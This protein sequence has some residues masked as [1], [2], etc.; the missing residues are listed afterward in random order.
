MIMQQ[1]GKVQVQVFETR[2]AMGESA[3]HQAA[4]ALRQA[5]AQQEKISCIF[6]AAPSQNEFLEALIAEPGIDWK[7]V[8]ACH[9]DEYVGLPLED[10]HSFGHF[11]KNSI[12]DR[13]PFGEVHFIN[14]CADPVEECARYSELLHE[15]KPE[16]VFMGI[17]ENGHIAFND[18]PVA[19]FQDRASVKV[20]MLEERCRC[21]QVHDGCFPSL[22]DVPTHAFT[23]TIPALMNC[24]QVFCV[25]PGERKAQ[26]VQDA[27]LGPVE[28][29]C[30]ASILREH[31]NAK[32]YLD[33]E[34]AALLFKH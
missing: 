12:F 19:N 33:K 5:L 23:L 24:S 13:V 8:T 2:N 3:T 18:P 28:T 7:R 25:V 4:E 9:M 17:G 11:L 26:A 22:Q 10:T 6:A 16:F 31:P 15:L 1:Y 29:D 30:P 21:Q 20:V 27:M 34:S 32:L 14:G